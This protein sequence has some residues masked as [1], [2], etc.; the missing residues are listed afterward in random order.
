MHRTWDCHRNC[1]ERLA[2]THGKVGATMLRLLVLAAGVVVVCTAVNSC[3]GESN[4]ETST[5]AKWALF[6]GNGI[7]LELPESFRGGDPADPLVRDVLADVVASLPSGDAKEAYQGMLDGV[8]ND[9]ETGSDS[10]D[11]LL[12]FGQPNAEGW[13]PT[14]QVWPMPRPPSQS[15]EEFVE[16]WCRRLENAT[17]ENLT[18]D[19][20]C[21]V[22]RVEGYVPE[23]QEKWTVQRVVFVETPELTGLGRIVFYTFDDPSNAALDEVFRI[24]AE[25]IRLGP[26]GYG[27]EEPRSGVR[28]TGLALR[29][30]ASAARLCWGC[31]FCSRG[32]LATECW[33]L[34]RTDTG[35]FDHV[36]KW[37][38]G[39][40]HSRLSLDAGGERSPFHS[41]R[42]AW[43]L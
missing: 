18:K 14:V 4:T 13:M 9:F 30:R 31:W 20:A 38:E 41:S 7:C 32:N 24:S 15:L 22:S 1:V 12:A 42:R 11:K 43:F 8:K 27:R 29:S 33:V 36:C 28:T 10:V 2:H 3:S 23:D 21:V 17:I 26:Y 37:C 39:V 16:N 35:A 5:S 6:E 40:W 25:T 34:P 19:W